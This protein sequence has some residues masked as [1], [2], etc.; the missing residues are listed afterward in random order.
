VY[1]KIKGVFG[2]KWTVTEDDIV[3]YD[4]VLN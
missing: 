1:Q 4:K 2:K 3:N